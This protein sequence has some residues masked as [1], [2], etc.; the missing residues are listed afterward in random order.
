ME[1]K[2]AVETENTREKKEAEGR[3]PLEKEAAGGGQ[4]TEQET[5]ET[6]DGE[7]AAKGAPGEDRENIAVARLA[8]S[9]SGNTD[10]SQETLDLLAI[11]SVAEMELLG[12]EKL[13]CELMARGL[14][15]GGTLQERAARLFSVRGL[16][17]EQIDPALFAKP[18]KGKKK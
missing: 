18:S 4:N 17:K 15:C 5:K 6:T 16:A 14:K 3:E 7:R 13:K 12:L 10:I 2:R 1:R 11:S 8:A 9:Q